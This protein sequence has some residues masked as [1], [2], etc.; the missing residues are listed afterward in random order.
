MEKTGRSKEETEILK[1]D[2]TADEESWGRI[3]ENIWNSE[4]DEDTAQSEAAGESVF[5][6]DIHMPEE[7]RKKCMKQI[8]RHYRRERRQTFAHRAGFVLLR[9]SAAVCVFLLVFTTSL[10]ASP[11]LR[12]STYEIASKILTGTSSSTED[13]KTE[14]PLIVLT[15]EEAEKD[16]LTGQISEKVTIDAYITP[17]SQYADGISQWTTASTEES[18][19]NEET[20]STTGVNVL[21]GTF[22]SIS[23]DETVLN[24]VSFSEFTSLFDTFADT[25]GETWVEKWNK[26]KEFNSSRLYFWMDDNGEIT[27]YTPGT[28]NTNGISSDL[29][30]GW[31]CEAQYYGLGANLVTGFYR[32]N[33]GG[34]S[35]SFLKRRTF[36]YALEELMDSLYP[37]AADR[38]SFYV[39]SEETL[40][41]L[42][43]D[44]SE[45][46]GEWYTAVCYETIEGLAVKRAPYSLSIPAGEMAE[47]SIRYSENGI[48]ATSDGMAYELININVTENGFECILRPRLNLVKYSTAKEVADIN[49]IIENMSA[50]IR[51][52]T[53]TSIVTEIELVMNYVVAQDEDGKYRIVYSPIWRVEYFNRINKDAD[54]KRYLMTFDGYTGELNYDLITY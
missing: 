35:T 5:E 2:V 37:E 41:E 51:K 34:S 31:G 25:L 27:I 22:E 20:A 6:S 9:F 11:S 8:R 23:G 33:D 24:S 45:I 13:A 54:W 40:T 38:Y 10:A 29:G 48:E 28:W 50:Q 16:H 15:D 18:E 30:Y 32:L 52:R 17:R 44:A 49:V 3:A 46:S 42:G 12:E 53:G 26:I 4:Y 1:D 47:D 14:Y 7:L 36:L 39:C 21:E 43:Y 19:E